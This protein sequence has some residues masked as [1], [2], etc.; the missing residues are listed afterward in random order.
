MLRLYVYFY[1]N[2]C[3]LAML[4]VSVQNPEGYKGEHKTSNKPRMK[5]KYFYRILLKDVFSPSFQLFH[6]IT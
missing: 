6:F 4:T 3:L 1:V 5:K 2:V